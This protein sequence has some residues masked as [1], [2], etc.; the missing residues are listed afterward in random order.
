MTTEL[1]V[2]S[3]VGESR[4]PGVGEGDGVGWGAGAEAYLAA[5]ST[6]AGCGAAEAPLGT[7]WVGTAAREGGGSS[8][9]SVGVDREVCGGDLVGVS[10]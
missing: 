8:A 4:L 10:E 7:A 3:P 2:G 9:G 6:V 1:A 5:C